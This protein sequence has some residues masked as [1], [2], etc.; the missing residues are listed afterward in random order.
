MHR[1]RLFYP[2]ENGKVFTD[3]ITTLNV[4][5]KD[6]SEYSELYLASNQSSSTEIETDIKIEEE[7]AVRRS[8]RSRKANPIIR[9]ISPICHDYRKNCKRMNSGISPGQSEAEP[10]KKDNTP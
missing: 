3:C 9:C 8:K 4:L 2:D 5:E 10:E 1:T 6:N 7:K